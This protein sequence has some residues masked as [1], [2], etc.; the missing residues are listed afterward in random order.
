MYQV[1]FYLHDY[2]EMHSQQNIQ[3]FSH[4]SFVSILTDLVPEL[5]FLTLYVSSLET[6]CCEKR[7]ESW[8]CILK[9]GTKG[10]HEFVQSTREG[11]P[12][13]S[14]LP[15]GCI[16]VRVKFEKWIQ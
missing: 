13:S 3:Q 14:S 4:I 2:I 12:K 15:R 9:S 5:Y 1:G 8:K 10:S 16:A 11:C 6:T 7:F